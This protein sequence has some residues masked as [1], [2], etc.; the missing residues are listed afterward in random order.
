MLSPWNNSIISDWCALVWPIR[1]KKERE[2]GMPGVPGLFFS[3][4]E[5]VRK[6]TVLI[7]KS[8]ILLS[9]NLE[10]EI[11][12]WKAKIIAFS[13]SWQL[14]RP[15]SEPSSACPS[16]PSQARHLALLSPEFPLLCNGCSETSSDIL[17]IK[18]AVV[19]SST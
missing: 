1:F 2:N 19:M 9:A 15:E 18:E 12:A 3:Y 17:G 7:P 11:P 6:I 13:S 4:L 14:R 16:C 10:M 5:E 8:F